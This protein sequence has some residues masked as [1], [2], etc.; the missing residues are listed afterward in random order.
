MS[1]GNCG[2]C[3]FSLILDAYYDITKLQNMSVSLTKRQSNAYTMGFW[4]FISDLTTF[5]DK[6]INFAISDLMQI[7]I[8]VDT[9]NFTSICHIFMNV[10]PSLLT[11]YSYSTLNGYT[12]DAN[13][14]NSKSQ[15]TDDMTN[16]WVY[17]R[18]AYDIDKKYMYSM[19]R[20][21]QG[22][23]MKDSTVEKTGL[24]YPGYYKD[25]P[26]DF[27]FV[28]HK[29]NLII[30]NASSLSNTAVYFKNIQIFSDLMPK[31]ANIQYL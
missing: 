28:S 25:S 9:T 14:I 2:G 10:Y 6:V 21:Y 31:E 16:K 8:G 29:S 1:S 11:T 26:F 13:F 18:C 30:N 23:A 17:T 19:T 12:S 7:S 3:K 20:S 4:L 24:A 5:G 27:P 15:L 22:G